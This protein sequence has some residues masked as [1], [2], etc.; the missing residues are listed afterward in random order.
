MNEPAAPLLGEAGF[1]RPLAA[2]LGI[3]GLALLVAAMVERPPPDFSTRRIVAVVRDAGDRP[4]WAIRLAGR[5]DQIA[6]DALRAEPHG[7]ARTYQ[8]WLSAA[9]GAALR[10]IGLLPEEGRKIIPVSP[11]NARRLAGAGRLV[12]TLEPK[13]GS[14]EPGPTGPVVFRGTLAGSG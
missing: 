8:L 10:Q 2:V 6:V 5:A 1:W 4:V 11:E 12:V 9:T 7:A 13:G 14:P 3:L